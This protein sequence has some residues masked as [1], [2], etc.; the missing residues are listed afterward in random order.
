MLNEEIVRNVTSTI[1]LKFWARGQVASRPRQDPAR[2][3]PKARGAGDR[4]NQRVHRP[5]DAHHSAAVEKMQAA[6]YNLYFRRLVC[7]ASKWQL[8]SEERRVGKECR[9]SCSRD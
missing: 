4:A 8:R 2:L 1:D 5:L 6:V 9:S 7:F 3:C